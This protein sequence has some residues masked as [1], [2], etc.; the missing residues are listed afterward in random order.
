MVAG[1]DREEELRAE[2]AVGGCG[3]VAYGSVFVGL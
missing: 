1:L 2:D 3:R